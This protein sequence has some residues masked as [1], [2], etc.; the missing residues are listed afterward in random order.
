MT[1]PRLLLALMTLLLV[2]F[3]F[4]PPDALAEAE[5][6][7]AGSVVPPDLL[8]TVAVLLAPDADAE[9]VAAAHGALPRHAV[10][11]LAGWWLIAFPD[12]AAAADAL[13]GLIADRRVEQAHAQFRRPFQYRVND[14]LF[15]SQWHLKKAG[16][17]NVDIN[18]EGA[19]N[20]GITGTG[21]RLM[22]CDDSLEH[23]HPDIAG[24]YDAANSYDYSDNDSNPAPASTNEQHGTPVAGMAAARGDNGVGVTG[25]AYTATLSAIRLDANF[26]DAAVASALSHAQSS[27]DVYSN[28]WGPPGW[29][30]LG[31]LTR[32]ALEQGIA[33]GRGGKGCIYVWASGN[34]RYWDDNANNDPFQTLPGTISVASI[35]RDGAVADHS[36]KGACILVAAPAGVSSGGMSGAGGNIVTTDRTGSAGYNGLTDPD[37]TNA[38]GGTSASCPTVAGVCA[39]I[40]QA[41]PNLTW[42]DVQHILVRSAN[43]TNGVNNNG[44]VQN[45]AGRRV[46]PTLGFGCVDAG[47]AVALAQGWS[48]VG[49][50]VTETTA[51]DNA[52]VGVGGITG[53]MRSLWCSNDLDLEHVE[54]EVQLAHSNWWGLEITLTSP[55]G[56]VSKLAEPSVYGSM[57]GGPLSP[58]GGAW[59]FMTVR[60]WDEKAGGN[61][62]LNIRD[63]GGTGGTLTNWR[64]KLHG[65]GGAF[66]PPPPPPTP[67][68]AITVNPTQLSLIAPDS[69]TPSAVASYSV[70]GVNLTA[71]VSVNAPSG[72]ELAEAAG[73][74]W[75]AALN[76]A[77]A[78]GNVSTT[79]Y[80]RFNPLLTGGANAT[81]Q[82]LHTSAGAANRTVQVNGAVAGSGGGGGGGGSGRSSGGGCVAT[83]GGG[84][85][86]LALLILWTRR[87]RQPRS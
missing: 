28:S 10:G 78:G 23:T 4:T 55:S 37:Y 79:V 40:L 27:I 39:L 14:P 54:I 62:T 86:C 25:V 6:D 11:T 24:N 32:Q 13:P 1:P 5:R 3:L 35:A 65:T 45:G 75:Q 38:F 17:A 70:S 7:P 68:P 72:I 43:S 47:A 34:G 2:P 30:D 41:N 66:V 56:T 60:N 20:A 67:T 83:G 49:T 31:T 71:D 69:T 77:Q 74:P 18:A 42:R 52:G 12:A 61:W 16:G 51:T 8:P 57:M 9:S 44:W 81:G 33:N 76:L 80:V 22:I 36:E 19:W 59:T 50:R 85:F 84:A 48:N 64:M 21:V 63:A 82:V 58:T 26:P 29:S 73:G 15:G 46:H 87:R 53:V